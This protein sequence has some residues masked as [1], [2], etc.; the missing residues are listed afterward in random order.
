MRLTLKVSHEKYIDVEIDSRKQLITI[1]SPIPDL[2]EDELKDIVLLGKY[3]IHLPITEVLYK[4][5][6]N[7]NIE[8]DTKTALGI[9]SMLTN[10][11]VTDK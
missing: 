8:L 10:F 4:I 7:E 6:N 5:E 3:S 2:T 1:L 11:L 9:V